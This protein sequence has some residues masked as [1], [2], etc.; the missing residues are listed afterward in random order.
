VLEVASR[1]DGVVRLQVRRG[2]IVAPDARTSARELELLLSAL[3]RRPEHDA[4]LAPGGL[5]PAPAACLSLAE[6]S[7]RLGTRDV[8]L[9][10]A[11]AYADA[12]GTLPVAITA[13]LDPAWL[14]E[15]DRPIVVALGRG[16]PLSEIASRARAPLFRVLALA[17]FLSDVGALAP[18]CEEARPLA[19]D[20]PV[21][22]ARAVALQTLGLP[23]D[24]SLSVAKSAFKR[25]ARALHPD[26]HPAASIHEKRELSLSLARLAAA[27]ASLGA[28]QA[29]R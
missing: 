29:A 5:G 22:P 17:S 21:D 3:S 24:A 12:A 2:E 13:R 20:V 19:R 26:A 6:I 10:R 28:M 9:E 4:L 11:R 16:G 15:P 14:A 23:P 27:Y 25:L 18:S 7:I 8:T 1:R